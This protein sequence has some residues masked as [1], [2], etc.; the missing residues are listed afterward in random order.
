LIS[1]KYA[2]KLAKMIDVY[3]T[4]KVATHGE[5]PDAP[6]DIFKKHT[7][8]FSVADEEGNWVACTATVNTTFGS[9]VVFPGTGVVM[10]DQMDDFSVQPGVPSAFRLV[11]GEAN[12]VA[13]GKHP[14]SSMSPTIVLKDGHPI[15]ALGAAGGPTIIS[16]VLQ[17][18][19]DMLDFGKTPDEALAT[20]RLHQQWSPDQLDV[21]K[22]L[23]E[24]LRTA[25]AARGHKV[26]ELSGRDRLSIAVFDFM[27]Q[28]R[29]CGIGHVNQTRRR[30][31]PRPS[32][33]ALKQPASWAFCWR[34]PPTVP[35]AETTTTPNRIQ[36]LMFSPI[37]GWP[38]MGP[39]AR[40][41][42]STSAGRPER[43]GGW[44]SFI[45]HGTCHTR[46]ALM[47]TPKP[48]RRRA[49][50]SFIGRKTGRP[51]TGENRS[52]AITS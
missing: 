45:G 41:Q 4:V 7:T 52:W 32:L 30:E 1:K 6:T 13:P 39:G 36:V 23:P 10:N 9:K 12:A 46:T 17:E 29:I 44:E 49:T 19:I 47:T 51:L 35:W 2:A 15:V 50:G 14:L 43:T 20:P 5:P 22:S 40:C 33:T 26:H 3:H 18:L 34:L 27:I 42:V 21:E 25:L 37:P 48:L 28:E 16:T 11:G 38:R 24:T 31:R 8:H